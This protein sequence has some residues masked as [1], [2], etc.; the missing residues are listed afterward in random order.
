MFDSVK[1]GIR[2]AKIDGIDEALVDG[3]YSKRSLASLAKGIGETE[4]D[5]AALIASAFP[6]VVKSVGR[7]SGK[8]YYS[9]E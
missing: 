1:I 8:V 7:N 4:A 3:R 2:A 5:T 6:S 9:A